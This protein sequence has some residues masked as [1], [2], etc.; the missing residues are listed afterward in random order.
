MKT[1]ANSFYYQSP[2]IVE[3]TPQK[4]Q[5]P[6]TPHPVTPKISTVPKTPS[7]SILRMVN[8]ENKR[9][10]V[11]FAPSNS[12]G[13]SSDESDLMELDVSQFSSSS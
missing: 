6:L 11:A 7:R 4:Q 13:L 1:F 3:V 12:P 9:R 2:P 10:K 8:S 5:A